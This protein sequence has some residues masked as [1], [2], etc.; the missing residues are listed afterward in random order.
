MNELIS[1]EKLVQEAKRKGVDF[2]K[3]DPYNRLRYYTKMGW[4]PHMVRKKEDDK[5]DVKGHY[6]SWTVKRILQIEKLKDQGYTN[7]EITK[8]LASTNF[9]D[10]IYSQLSSSDMKVKIMIYASFLFL[11]MILSVELGIF[12]FGRSKGNNSP[13]ISPETK[14]IINSGASYVPSQ[15]RKVMVKDDNVNQGSKVYVSFNGNY[16]PAE[17]YWVAEIIPQQ[18][19][20]V[21]LDAPVANDSDFT[22]WISN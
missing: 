21:E 9:I 4:L 10:S 3:G 20:V 19:F 6:P 15:Q 11:L 13:V 7:E 2:G 22:W 1:T 14:L 8:K 12:N 16:S 17:R 5:D 18:G